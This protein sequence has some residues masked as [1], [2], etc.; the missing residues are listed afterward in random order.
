MKVKD[1]TTLTDEELQ[2]SYI[3]F[4]DFEDAEYE[5][6]GSGE[7]GAIIERNLRPYHEAFQEEFEK[8]GMLGENPL[9]GM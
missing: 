1:L 5:M 7:C 2:E 6:D 3:S 9:I 4:L 8:R